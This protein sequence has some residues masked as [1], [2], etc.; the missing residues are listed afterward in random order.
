MIDTAP[1]F[2]PDWVSPP[3]E[4][5]A[6]LLEERGWIQ[7]ELAERLGYTPKHLNQLIKGKVPLSEDAALR[8]ERVLDGKAGFWLSR[9]ARYRERLA[10]LDA[11]QR[12]EGWSGWLDALPVKELM[13]AGVI[14]KRRL[15]KKHRP[16]LVEELLRFFGVAS[17]D[18]WK[19]RYGGLQ[20]SFRRGRADHSDIGAVSAWLRMGERLAERQQAR[21]YDRQR[22]LSALDEIRAL[23]LESP[24]V[25]EPRL[26]MLCAESGVCLVLVPAIPRAHV[27]GAARWLNA[28]RPLIQLSLYGKTNDRFWFTFFHEAAHL[29]L[30]AKEKKAVFLDDTNDNGTGS[31]QECEANH[32]AGDFLIPLKHRHELAALK[33]KKQV[34]AFSSKIEIHP[35]IIVGR[36]QHE[37]I[38]PTTWMNDL[39]VSLRFLE[40]DATPAAD[41]Q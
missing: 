11:R 20:V 22:F 2:S 21:R 18:D 25:F 17:P 28:H 10:R 41:E 5:I 31:Q 7:A 14:E 34:D 9:E 19:N 12:F 32:W 27:S 4:T 1:G 6:D 38:I 29:L 35:G 16:G 33:S 3:G 30:H 24:D 40:D 8:L 39:K 36:L 15:D 37:Q 26:R 13:K 23:T